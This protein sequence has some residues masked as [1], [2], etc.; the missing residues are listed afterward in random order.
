MKTTITGSSSLVPA[1]AQ[2]EAWTAHDWDN[3]LLVTALAPHDRLTVRTCNSTYEIIVT[4][5][6]TAEVL[7]RG[8]H[9]FPEFTRAR[10][11]GSSLGGSF[12]KLHGVYAGFQLEL[13]AGDQPIVTTRVRT[14]ALTPAPDGEVM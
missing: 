6:K 7:V 4:V 1:A 9:F 2:F 10:I 8:G 12:L 5:P 14:I 11:S 3:G 13:I